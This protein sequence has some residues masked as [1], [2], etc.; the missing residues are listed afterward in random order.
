MGL[1]SFS[2]NRKDFSGFKANALRDI[3]SRNISWS[4]QVAAFMSN[5]TDKRASVI[6]LVSFFF[7]RRSQAERNEIQQ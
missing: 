4:D 5:Y 1:F 3:S 7:A 2:I 6:R